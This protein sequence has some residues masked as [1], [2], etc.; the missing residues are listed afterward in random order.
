[1]PEHF[2][3]IAQAFEKQARKYGSRAFLKQKRDKAWRDSSWSEIA[4]AAAK[5]RAGL[6]AM[7][8]KPGDRVAILSDNSPQWVIVDQA[9][10]GLGAIVVPL[11]TT[12][13]SEEHCHV[14][15]DSSAKVVAANGDDMVKKIL[16]LG[17]S[18]PSVEATIAVH[19][20]ATPQ[21]ASNGT[22]RVMTLQSA[23]GDAAAPIVE[24]KREDLATFIYTS[25]TTGASKGVMLTHGNLLANAEDAVA[26]LDVNENDNILSF[27]PV[28]HCFERTAGYYTVLLGGG[29]IAYAE[30]LAQIPANLQE[31]K[32]TLLLVVPR[33][34]EAI[35]A[36]VQ[37]TVETSPPLRQKLF[38]VAIETGKRATEYLHRGKSVPPLLALQMAIFRKLVF[39]R[40]TSIFGGR[41]RYLISGGA[42]LPTEIYRFLAA[43]EVPIIEGY[44]LTEAAP[45][46]SVNLLP[47]R[48]RIGSVG[49]RLPNVEAKTANDGELLVRG[50]N[51]MKGYF[52]LDNETKEAIDAEGW[53]HTGDVAQIDSDGFIKIT[54]RKKE[55][56]VLS[57][58]KNISPA[59]LE[60]KLA[61]DSYI[62]QVCVFGDRRKHLAALI[63][64][65]FE[66]LENL[67]KEKG[68][69]G[70][71]PEEI[72]K[73]N[74]LRS[75]YQA[76]L[77]EFNKPLSD[78]E[79]I[80]AF[81]LIATPF[82]QE[83]GEMTPTMKVR[84]KAV[85][86]HHRDII[87]AMFRD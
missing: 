69:A 38:G 25:G 73:S 42:P 40:I 47:G 75:V 48:A 63:V 65:N 83:N 21:A 9:V 44:G 55:I 60:T 1:M 57:G 29:Q 43:A 7:G 77:R 23:S 66:N 41:L 20:D 5:L 13:G 50:P 4:D 31:I 27:L 46:V 34:L 11:Y 32:P 72:V 62:S 10:L 6:V 84:R 17:S 79:A 26:V 15:N 54:D 18:I 87:D 82:S 2:G 59:Y 64:P 14:L 58:G 22:R 36:R 19:P 80:A 61:T 8:V 28:A 53:L 30:G 76:R 56:I 52:K 3:T 74:E 16:A 39:H 37:K 85:Q 86:Q 71:P 45:I 12:S 70:K 81:T 33:L 49:Q 51:V 67:L 68:L 78:V 24:G 35:Y